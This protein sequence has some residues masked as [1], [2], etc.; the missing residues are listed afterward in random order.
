VFIILQYFV[1]S[2][3]SHR[4]QWSSD[5]TF[6]IGPKI[7]EL[8]S[9]WGWWIFKAIKF[10]SM[11]FFSEEVKRSVPCHRFTACYI[12]L[13][14][15]RRYFMGKIQ[16]PFL[17]HV[18]L[19]LLLD[20]SAGIDCQRAQ[21]NESGIIWNCMWHWASHSLLKGKADNSQRSC[22]QAVRNRNRLSLAQYLKVDDDDLNHPS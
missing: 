10:H 5:S 8:K 4:L 14:V 15:W 12:T 18:S 22:K 17:Y 13:Q 9:G 19:A 3:S 11:T 21:V 1:E 16:Q 20:D 2:L 6:A 7:S